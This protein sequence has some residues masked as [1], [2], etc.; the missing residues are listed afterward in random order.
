[1][2]NNTF[3][4]KTIV[5]TGHTGFKGA[6]LTAWLNLLGAR[7][8]GI[9][10][11]PVS[12]PNHFALG[13][14][15]QSLIHNSI[16]I[17]N[18]DEVVRVIKDS[19]PDFVFH[20]AA[21]ALVRTSYEDP[22]LTWSTNVLGT[23]NILE[24]LKKLS[25]KCIAILITSDKCYENVEWTWGY[26]ENDRLGG[27]DPYSASKASAELLIHSYFRSFFLNPENGIR[28]ATARA[29]NV[30]GGGDWSRDR[31]IPDCVRAW[32]N[33]Q[34]V[35]LRNPGSTRPWQHVLEPLG[36]YLCL[37][38]N[39]YQGPKLHGESF[40]FGPHSGQNHSVLELVEEMA[41]YW[42]QVRWVLADPSKVSGHEATLLKLNCD[43]A[44][45]SLQWRPTLDFYTTT[46]MT[47]EWYKKYYDDE[48][49]D[50]LELT[51]TQINEYYLVSKKLGI[52]WANS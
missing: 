25:T 41:K 49:I 15:S 34:E 28:I 6:W 31:I 27:Q 36:G 46:K 37:A 47:A 32:S 4:G 17:R 7:V 19:K 42:P 23:L 16:D 35:M 5:L 10:L 1:M 3:A 30:I 50:I 51:K 18:F 8:V 11:D 14:F 20:L 21:Q 44:L 39:L 52:E 33:N 22:S 48:S 45:H 43:K 9:S 12:H 2:F 26:R 24:S 13:K 29:G 40:N 38:A